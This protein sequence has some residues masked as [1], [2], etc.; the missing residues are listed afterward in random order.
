MEKLFS[1]K[2]VHPRDRFAYWHDVACKHIV[3]H[4]SRPNAGRASK[5]NSKRGRWGTSVW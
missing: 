2:D 4:N 5:P 3:E 1:T